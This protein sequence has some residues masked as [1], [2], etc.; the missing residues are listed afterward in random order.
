MW[1]CTA[2]IVFAIVFGAPRATASPSM[3]IPMGVVPY[4]G[5]LDVAD[6]VRSRPWPY[7]RVQL[8]QPEE[9][10]SLE[11]R[12][13]AESP[14]QIWVVLVRGL[15]TFS[16]PDGLSSEWHFACVYLDGETLEML[17]VQLVASPKADQPLG[18]DSCTLR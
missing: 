2:L 4:H 3:R 13:V 6:L 8:R 17:Q 16:A 7:H 15:A 1:P 14:R 10:L 5:P 11:L 12:P 18:F 9:V